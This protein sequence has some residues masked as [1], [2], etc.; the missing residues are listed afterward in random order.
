[1]FENANAIPV[2][3]SNKAIPINIPMFLL[4]LDMEVHIYIQQTLLNIGFI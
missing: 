2:N 3:R 4:K 1:M